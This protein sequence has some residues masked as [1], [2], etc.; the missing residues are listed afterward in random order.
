MLTKT[1]NLAERTTH[2]KPSV[3][4]EILKL[5]QRPNI[6]S[7]AGG[8]PSPDAFPLEHIG[9]ATARVLEKYGTSA[10][11]YS[12]TEGFPQL[13]EW[14]AQT[15]SSRGRSVVSPDQVLITS[16]SQQALDLIGKV[17]LDPGSLVAVES[18]TYMG[19]L[20]A[21]N[22]YQAQYTTMDMDEDGVKLESLEAALKRSPR[23]AYLLPNY[24]NPSGIMLSAER[25]LEAA[26][27]AERYG[28]PLL[29]DDA[30]A[31]LTFDGNIPPSLYGY[32]P[33]NTIYV[34]TF[35]K[36]LAPGLRLAWIVADKNLI[37]KLVE[38]KQGTD[39]H[40]SSFGQLL[41]YEC[42]EGGFLEEHSRFISSLYGE[43]CAR[44]LAQMDAHFP[45]E[46]TWTRPSGG[47]FVWV[48]LPQ[49]MSA[50]KLFEVALEQEVAFVPGTPFYANGGGENTLRLNFSS[51]SLEKIDLGIERLGKAIR[52]A[53]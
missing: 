15:V 53:M 39:L 11:Q 35:S 5:T 41:A 30:Y 47:M 31:G 21:W 46:V 27:M 40:T 51:S 49:H 34:G 20:Q 24:Q 28:V 14:V 6:I 7:F 12:T 48:T 50:Q 32:A 43:R 16:G 10:L 8:L 25:R 26:K 17:F 45:P 52:D 4:R 2:I 29:E 22:A 44:M 36:T 37:T 1:W 18:P 42:I 33:D 19:A 9:A 23:F 38:T 3:I 13:R